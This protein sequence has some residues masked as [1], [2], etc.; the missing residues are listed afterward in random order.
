MTMNTIRP[1]LSPLLVGRDDLLDLA[2]RRLNES[3]A[4]RGPFLLLAGESG[5]GK[6]RLLDAI[7]QKAEGRGFRVAWGAVARQCQAHHR[8]PDQCRDRQ[9]AVDRPEDRQ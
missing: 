2:D 8:G 5:I 6:T 4:G 7:S 9:G 3:A 1:F